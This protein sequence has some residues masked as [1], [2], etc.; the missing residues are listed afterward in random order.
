MCPPAVS[1]LN[2]SQLLQRFC[3]QCATVQELWK[4]LEPRH[5]L[6]QTGSPFLPKDFEAKVVLWRVS[7]KK[8]NDL[9]L[10]TNR[11]HQI[12][13]KCTTNSLYMQLN[14]HFRFP[15]SSSS[16]FKYCAGSPHP[17]PGQPPPP[18]CRQAQ[19]VFP[20]PHQCHLIL[21]PVPSLSKWG[22]FSI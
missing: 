13:V 11:S 5:A 15:T 8:R 12:L 16:L 1:I 20:P 14:L 7:F 17:D 2:P 3:K 19:S 21:S 4:N 6:V 18:S 10:R 9:H 22:H